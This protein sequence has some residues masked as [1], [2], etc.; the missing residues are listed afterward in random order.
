[1]NPFRYGEVVTKG[2]FCSRPDLV[3]RL[4]GYLEGGHNGVVMGERR[5]GKT[6]LIHES[7]RRIRGLRLVYAQFWAVKSIEEIA[8]R[9]LR[10]IT[11]SQTKGSFLER[12][13]RS[14][15][16]LRP[17]IE[18]DPATGQPSVAIAPGT[19][20]SPEGLHGVFDLIEELGKKHRLA[21]ALDE[22]QDIRDVPDADAVLGEIRG[23]IQLQAGISYVFAGSIRHEMERIFRD[24]SKP[25]FKSLR[26][27][28]VGPI[29]RGKFRAFL[30]T[31]FKTGK[32][33]VSPE[34]IEEVFALADDN[35]SDVQQF[36]S[37]LWETTGPGDSI[38]LGEIQTALNHVFATERKGFE[39]MIK[40]LTGQ[41]KKCL[42]ALS[43]LGGK[44]PQ[45]KVFLAEAGIALPTS[46]KRALTRLVDLEIVYGADAEYKF[47]DPFFRE[48]VAREL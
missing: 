37:A 42:R 27:V 17:Q 23:R 32:R 14:L 34:A 15:A 41:Q 36:C 1:M 29:D 39:S 19:K 13:G 4:R 44:H 46:V 22:F 10:G 33:K 9:M 12:I 20:M 11:T 47:F 31:R 3:R 16:Y 8:T 30:E 43:R 28:E 35:P 40:I 24:P 6:S 38:G 26:V 25:F 5:T 48:W 18:F 45:S 7:A 2:E 21:V